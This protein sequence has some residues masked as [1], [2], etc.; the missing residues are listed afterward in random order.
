MGRV[1]TRVRGLWT[2]GRTGAPFAAPSVRMT[3]PHAVPRDPVAEKLPPLD[4]HAPFLRSSG[5]R[6]GITRHRLDGPDF[7]RV[8][9]TVRVRATVALTPL[10]LTRAARLLVPTAVASHQTAARL[11]GG[12]VPDTQETH[13]IV[14]S[15]RWRRRRPGLHCHVRSTTDTRPVPGTQDGGGNLLVTTPEQTFVDLATELTLVD[16]VV[17]GDSLVLK[18]VTTTDALLDAA[19]RATGP[20]SAL[21]RQAAAL[22]RSGAESGMETRTRL[23]L[24]L[25]GLPEPQVNEWVLDDSG[26]GRYRLD[27]PY[28]DLRLAF[29]YDGRQHAESS[30]QWGWDLARRE[31]LDGEGWRLVVFRSEDIYVSPWETVRRAQEALAQRG[32][33][34]DLPEVAPLEFRRHFP[35]QPWRARRG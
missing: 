34:V 20:G 26:R 24:V 32:F 16:L 6:T 13:V 35:G 33:L 3:H 21:A 8:F 4:E 31:W 29:E 7:H 12:L 10:T 14:T 25:G 5:I 18:A 9:G 1:A 17:L 22:V 23:L 19:D 30:T 2:T 27:L 15:A 11:W 28:P